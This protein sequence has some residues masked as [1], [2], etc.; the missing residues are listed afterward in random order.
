MET[1][2]TVITSMDELQEY[3]Q[4]AHPFAHA[5]MCDWMIH[6]FGTPGIGTVG[7][8]NYDFFR[9]NYLVLLNF[10][11]PNSGGTFEVSEIRENGDIVVTPIGDFVLRSSSAWYGRVELKKNDFV[12]N[13]YPARAFNIVV[14][15]L[16]DGPTLP[17]DPVTVNNFNA[18]RN[19]IAIAGAS[20]T[21]IIIAANITMPSSITIPENA[22]ITLI[23]DSSAGVTFIINAGDRR[24]FIVNGKLTIGSANNDGA[25]NIILT[26][27]ANAT[28]SGGVENHGTF[29]MNGGAIVGNSTRNDGGG[30]YNS[31]TFIINNG[32]V[33][34]NSAN[35]NGNNIFSVGTLIDN[36]GV[37]TTCECGVGSC[38]GMLPCEICN[39]VHCASSDCP[40][41]TDYLCVGGCGRLVGFSP[42]LCGNCEL[43]KSNHIKLRTGRSDVARSI[44][45]VRSR[46]ELNNYIAQH[47][48]TALILPCP[49]GE[50]FAGYTE[51]YFSNGGH[52]AIVYMAEGSGSISHTVEDVSFTS[53]RT[54]ISSPI[55]GLIK[56]AR[57]VPCMGMGLTADMAYHHI[58][59]EVNNAVINPFDV[60]NREFNYD[61]TV[62]DRIDCQCGGWWCQSY[63][64]AA[65]CGGLVDVPGTICGYC[66]SGCPC[67]GLNPETCIVCRRILFPT[68]AGYSDND[69]Q[70]L[71]KF[72]LQGN[73]LEKLSWDLGSA[74]MKGV[75]WLEVGSLKRVTYI[76]FEN[77]GKLEGVLDLSDFSE[78][79]ELY[80]GDSY[81]TEINL[82]NCNRFSFLNGAGNHLTSL[83]TLANLPSLRGLNVVGNYLDLDCPEIQADLDKIRNTISVNQRL[84]Q[85]PLIPIGWFLMYTPQRTPQISCQ[86]PTSEPQRSPCAICD[87]CCLC[88]FYCDNHELE[89]CMCNCIDKCV[90]DESWCVC[91]V[92]T[93]CVVCTKSDCICNC[94]DCGNYDCVCKPPI[95]TMPPFTPAIAEGD[96]TIL[97]ALEI[98]KYLVNMPNSINN[99]T[100][101]PTINDALEV[102]K[103]LAKM[104]SVFDSPPVS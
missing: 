65:G 58:V 16:I 38:P 71:V 19:A 32:S 74:K 73:N 23:S 86:C 97:D 98:L 27:P 68:P 104:P 94:V 93:G 69:Y 35:G 47:R 84:S 3:F 67:M 81:V 92:S 25:S 26:R 4:A 37:E 62:R 33:S 102:L 90:C 56:I 51:E 76:D 57:N 82:S 43:W 40:P 6:W 101:S 13:N 5:V 41:L 24:H 49:V 45:V 99:D 50:K 95:N 60:I 21:T 48:P 29:V 100:V 34:G 8:Y 20:P 77:E 52:L 89:G 46:A 85:N 14:D 9:E 72:A 80:L 70:K 63:Y 44:T 103:Y 30:V 39:R 15:N 28:Y 91:A 54:G 7:D 42:E 22:N 55:Q 31:G 61:F 11:F 17:A 59:I 10:G 36:R 2:V 96:P 88:Q 79:T 66:P 18:L 64:C 83:S 75:W 12:P 1:P 53:N 78:L 87:I